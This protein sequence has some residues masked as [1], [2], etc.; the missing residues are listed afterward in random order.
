M[1]NEN[2]EKVIERC[3]IYIKEFEAYGLKEEVLKRIFEFVQW[4]EKQKLEKQKLEGREVGEFMIICYDIER[5]VELA[6]ALSKKYHKSE[7]EYYRKW[8]S[9]PFTEKRGLLH[10]SY[11]MR[12]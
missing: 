11:A 3:K 9:L 4:L 2:Y 7:C 6:K 10:W 5:A 12:Q 1:S 8:L